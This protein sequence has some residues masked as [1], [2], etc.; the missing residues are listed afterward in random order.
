MIKSIL[1]PFDGSEHARAALRYAISLSRLD[2]ARVDGLFVIDIQTLLQPS[3]PPLAGEALPIGGVNI[4]L[5]PNLELQKEW[6]EKGESMLKTFEDLC[7]M[8]G[9]RRG[10]T[11]LETGL[12]G[13][14]ICERGRAADLV[15][16]GKR[17]ASEEMG[18]S[19]E[20]LGPVAAEVIRNSI[21][22]VMVAPQSYKEIRHLL[23]AYDGSEAASR[24]LQLAA[25][26]GAVGKFKLKVL[27]VADSQ[28]EGR[29]IGREAETYLQAY[30]LQPEILV[31]EG[32]P[33]DTLRSV[34]V[35]EAIDLIVMGAFGKSRLRELLLGSTT[36][37]V[38]RYADCPV[39]LHR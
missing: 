7:D 15:V 1:V 2:Q 29:K 13:P 36:Q 27:V 19:E 3:T 32:N 25:Y 21:R 26:L 33:A 39:L 34:A 31:E 11:I 30:E 4:G 16:L 8:A 9:V 22:P 12:V 20:P 18:V 17:G 10:S 23:M 38:V 35:R 24:A 37:N 5:V 28:E 14:T 6:V